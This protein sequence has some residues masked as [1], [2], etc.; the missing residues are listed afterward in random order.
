MSER[1]RGEVERKEDGELQD[2]MTN[3][4]VELATA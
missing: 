2:S 4:G 3:M 1:R